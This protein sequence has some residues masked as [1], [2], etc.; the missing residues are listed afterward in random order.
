MVLEATIVCIDNSEWMRNGDYPPS[1]LAAQADAANLICSAKVSQ[2]RENTVGLLTMAGKSARMLVTQTNDDRQIITSLHQVRMQC[3]RC[4][5]L[6]L[7]LSLF[8]EY[9]RLNALECFLCGVVLL[10]LGVRGMG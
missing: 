10:Y 6:V 3:C 4:D 5:V 9:L 7:G 2:N 8:F 1:R